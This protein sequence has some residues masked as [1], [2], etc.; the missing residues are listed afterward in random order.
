[1]AVLFDHTGNDEDND[2]T[3]L[4]KRAHA[5]ET[6]PCYFFWVKSWNLSK[7]LSPNETK[8]AHKPN[9]IHFVSRQ[10]RVSIPLH[11][12]GITVPIMTFTTPICVTK[13]LI[14]QSKWAKW[15]KKWTKMAKNGLNRASNGP[16]GLKSASNHCFW[17]H[18]ANYSEVSAIK[19]EKTQISE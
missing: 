12:V 18:L 11:L 15:S 2:D 1:M 10:K 9:A 6:W 7:R 16:K 14:W 5:A 4:E 13:L 17:I 3:K 19:L 8:R